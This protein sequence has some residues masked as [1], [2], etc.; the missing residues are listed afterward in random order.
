MCSKDG[1]RGRG[2]GLGQR[3][4]RRGGP[5]ACLLRSLHLPKYYDA[6]KEKPWLL[7]TFFAATA[8]HR[9]PLRV[10]RESLCLALIPLDLVR[11][12]C[13][14]SFL[15]RAVALP[16]L[17][18]S[19]GHEERHLDDRST[20]T[21]P[22]QILRNSQQPVV[23]DP[24]VVSFIISPYSFSRT[25]MP[26]CALPRVSLAFPNAHISRHRR[27]PTLSLSS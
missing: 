2:R 13:L 4:R 8:G 10:T 7:G 20:Q 27:A 6:W 26:S 25:I 1:E 24:I 23:A 3:R 9:A 12:C 15:A 19:E 22:L 16:R 17:A 21:K 11:A 18:R 14:L 5:L